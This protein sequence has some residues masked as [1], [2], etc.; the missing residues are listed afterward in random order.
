MTPIDLVSM[1]ARKIN[2]TAYVL[3]YAPC[4]LI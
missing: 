4:Y 1:L 3:A 2:L